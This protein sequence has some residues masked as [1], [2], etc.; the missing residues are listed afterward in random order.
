[1]NIQNELNELL[2]LLE[3]DYFINAHDKCEDLWRKYKNDESTRKESFILKSFVNG[4][5]FL[6]LIKMDRSEHANKIWL[7]FKKY[8]NLIDELYSINKLE[9]KKLQ[10]LIYKKRDEI[11]I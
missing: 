3:K 4:I 1:M 10:K 5:A 9:Y 8:E 11:K 2:T 6:E 7:I